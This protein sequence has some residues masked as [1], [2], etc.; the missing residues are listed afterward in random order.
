MRYTHLA[1]S[2]L[3]AILLLLQ[4]L[5]ALQS[6]GIEEHPRPEQDWGHL[7]AAGANL[8]IL[9]HQTY[10]QMKESG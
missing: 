2:L 10:R 8:D 9:V 4:R 1:L 7:C 3:I 5:L 6:L